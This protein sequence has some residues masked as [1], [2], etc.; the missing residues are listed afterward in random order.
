MKTSIL[1]LLDE[2]PLR[3]LAPEAAKP[4][5][6]LSIPPCLTAATAAADEPQ[7][8]RPLLLSFLLVLMT[9]YALVQ[10]VG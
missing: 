3:V 7:A 5:A 9:Y 1:Q 6:D 10:F 4:V 8:L 2:T